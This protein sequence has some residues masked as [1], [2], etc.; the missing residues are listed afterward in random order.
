MKQ[1]PDAK[2]VR[3]ILV[4]LKRHIRDDYRASDEDTLPSMQ[5]TLAWTPESGEWDIQTGD[6]SYSGAAYGHPHW[7]VGALYRRSNCTTLT[8]DL[9]NQLDQLTW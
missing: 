4:R 8:G 1:F 6:N 2:Q 3:A 5:I 7:A 9:I